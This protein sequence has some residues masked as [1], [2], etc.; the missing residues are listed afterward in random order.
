MSRNRIVLTLL[1]LGGLASP[2]YAAAV[3]VHSNEA[4][5]A[6][7]DLQPAASSGLHEKSTTQISLLTAELPYCAASDAGSDIA[8]ALP[9]Y[10]RNELGASQEPMIAAAGLHPVGLMIAMA[11]TAIIPEPSAVV[12]MGM[13]AAG[14]LFAAWRRRHRV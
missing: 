11:T 12:L 13:G 7:L 1:A 4:A 14:M 9:N 2:A 5:F 6:V 8:F 3:S 10:S